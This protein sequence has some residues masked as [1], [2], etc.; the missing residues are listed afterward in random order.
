MINMNLTDIL[1]KYDVVGKRF[2]SNDYLAEINALPEIERQKDECRFEWLAFMLQ[3]NDSDHTFGGYFGP[4]FTLSDRQGN[5]VYVPEFSMITPE[6]V[7]YWEQRYKVANNVLM[8]MRYAGLVWDFK[9]RIAKAKNDSDLYRTYVD[10]MLEVCNNDYTSHPVVT[11]MVLERLFSITS[12]QQVDL[13]KAKDA[14]RSFENR[15]AIDSSVRYWSCQFLLMTNN[16]KCFTQDEI[17]DLLK[18]HEERM[19]RLAAGN[20]DGSIDIWTLDSQCKLLADYYLHSQH[21]DDIA[22]VMKVSEDAH[23]K[24]FDSRDPLQKLAILNNLF[25]KYTYYGLNDD[26]KRLLSEIQQAGNQTANT[27]TSHEYEF[28]IPQSVYEQAEEM[29][30]KKAT[31]DE[32]R[33]KNFAIYFIPRKEDEERS[34]AELVKKYPMRYM[35]ATQMLDIKGRPQSI[36]GTYEAD[37]EGNLVMK[38]TE[39]MNLES[40]YLGIAINKMR[41]ASLITTDR[42]M[43]V[44]EP[45]PLFDEDSYGIIRQALD[46]LFDNKPII[47]CHLLIPQLEGAIRNLVEADGFSVIKQQ[48]DPSK[49]FQLITLDDLLRTE[50]V[51]YAFTADGAMYLRL[52]LTDQRSLNIRNN[53]CHGLLS[54]EAFHYGVA[55]RLFHVLVMIGSVR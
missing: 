53:L 28:T 8:K 52:V 13:E 38:I 31:S 5:P 10:S 36:I 19:K 47:F 43:S 21:K 15:H 22:R 9:T 33:W 51:E 20:P 49:G 45:C 18:Q 7:L 14:M 17:N 39:K 50:P 27:L 42:I 24:C 41:E 23:K 11:T 46:S 25:R 29:F 2:N 35:A 32:V 16:K 3:P 54:P 30:G 26:A 34:L 55:V 12:K 37:P 6:A 4:Q 44:I 48:K 40:H 1:L